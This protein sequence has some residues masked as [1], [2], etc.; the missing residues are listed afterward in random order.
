MR[1]WILL[2]FAAL[3]FNAVQAEE[4]FYTNKEDRYYHADAYC[5]R[6]P[7]ES[8]FQADNIEIF[9]REIYK[10]YPVSEKAAAEFE[11]TACPVCVKIFEPVYLGDHLPEQDPDQLLQPW[12]FESGWTSI[13]DEEFKREVNRT[14]EAFYAYFEEYAEYKT[15]V[16]KR[17]HDYPSCYGGTYRNI[18]GGFTYQ[19][20]DPTDEILSAFKKMFGGGAWIVSVKYGYNEMQKTADSIFAA[21]DAWC[22]NHPELDARPVYAG[23]ETIPNFVCIGINGEDWQQA[24]AAMDEIAPIYVHFARSEQETLVYED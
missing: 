3:L 12:E 20:V 11:K 18:Q 2:L 10:K 16:I 9:D 13:R 19:I 7:G 8:Y 23:V 17:K 4:L 15:G 21:L 6:N 22:N 14:H 5:D 1:K 24:A